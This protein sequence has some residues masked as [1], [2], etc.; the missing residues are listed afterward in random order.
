M[1]SSFAYVM[2]IERTDS[3]YDYSL[4]ALTWQNINSFIISHAWNYAY[5]YMK[6]IID[7]GK[8]VLK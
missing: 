6:Y 7:Y 8:T 4:F 1:E 2:T 5:I 3:K